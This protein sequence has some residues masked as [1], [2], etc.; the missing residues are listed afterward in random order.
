[1]KQIALVVYFIFGA[2]TTGYVR[3]ETFVP[4]L[5]CFVCRRIL[6]NRRRRKFEESYKNQYQSVVELS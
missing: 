5:S 2:A 4:V 6:N 3:F 1:M